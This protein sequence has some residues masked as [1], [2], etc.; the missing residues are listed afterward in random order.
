MLCWSAFCWVIKT[1]IGQF[2]KE[3]YHVRESYLGVKV[4]VEA[5]S[6]SKPPC[7]KEECH[8]KV[9]LLTVTI[10][11]VFLLYSC[12]TNCWEKSKRKLELLLKSPALGNE[13]IRFLWNVG[14]P[15]VTALNPRIHESS[16]LILFLVCI[17]QALKI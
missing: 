16:N 7:L 13:G 1:V 10:Y 4:S 14:K 6:S 9:I 5:R 15:S 11:L 8:S 17:L 12:V 2:T 3:F